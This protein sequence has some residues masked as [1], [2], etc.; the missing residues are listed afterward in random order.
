MVKVDLPEDSGTDNSWGNLDGQCLCLLEGFLAEAMRDD[1]FIGDGN[2]ADYL[3]ASLRLLESRLSGI[4]LE[5]CRRIRWCS[6]RGTS[7]PGVH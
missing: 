5:M 6:V 4:E 1:P 3:N 2:F 7:S